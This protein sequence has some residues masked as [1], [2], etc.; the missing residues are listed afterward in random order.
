MSRIKS[1]SIESIRLITDHRN[2]TEAINGG[3]L[4]IDCSAPVTLPG[5][6]YF[7]ED[8]FF[9]QESLKMR[10]KVNFFRNFPAEPINILPRG[11]KRGS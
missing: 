1:E 3:V 5:A 2:Y 7:A 4:Q 10:K 6:K 11:L 9:F 8:N